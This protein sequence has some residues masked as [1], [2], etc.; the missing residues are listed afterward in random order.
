MNSLST[1]VII[2][3]VGTDKFINASGIVNLFRGIGC[4]VGPFIG[5]LI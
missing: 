3:L 2:E 5:G 4:F 1:M